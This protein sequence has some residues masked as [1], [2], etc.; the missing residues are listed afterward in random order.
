MRTEQQI[1]EEK[2]MAAARKREKQ[3]ESNARKARMKEL[4]VKAE[5]M[6]KKSDV[7]IAKEATANA[8][9]AMAQEKLTDNSDVVKQLKSMAARAQAFSIRDKQLEERRVAR[10]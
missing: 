7:E 2:E 4:E 5:K 8:L 3:A 1:L 10:G 6:K 9:R